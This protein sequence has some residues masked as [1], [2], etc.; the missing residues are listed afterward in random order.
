MELLWKDVLLTL[1][2]TKAFFH[3][4][5]DSPSSTITVLVVDY[6]IECSLM[7]NSNG[8]LYGVL[9]HLSQP[10]LFVYV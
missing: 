8:F 7:L 10:V 2:N 4:G 1:K 3:Q 9:E 6:L 5:Q